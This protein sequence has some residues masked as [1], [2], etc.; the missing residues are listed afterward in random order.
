GLPPYNW[1]AARRNDFAWLRMRARRMAALYD[2]FRV[3]HLVGFYRT[4]VRPLD[5]RESY[6]FP[7]DEE[8]QRELGET[9]LQIMMQ[10]GADVS[11]EDLGTVPDFVR[12]SVARLGLPGYKVIRWE[13]L[14]PETY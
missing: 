5:G 9:C 10:T 3:D 2:G 4:Y 8:D 13:P 14:G 7:S 6:F 12:E 11:G 1:D